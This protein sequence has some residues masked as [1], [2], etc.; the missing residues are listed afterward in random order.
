[1]SIV[2]TEYEECLEQLENWAKAAAAAKENS[3]PE[4]SALGLHGRDLVR[5]SDIISGLTGAAQLLRRIYLDV[6]QL[7]EEK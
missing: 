4:D 7:E 6:K 1:M 3:T 5:F 2:I